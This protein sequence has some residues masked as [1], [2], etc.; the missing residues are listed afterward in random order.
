[1]LPDLVSF[2]PLFIYAFI[3]RSEFWDLIS[4][5]IWVVAYAKE[6]YK[7]TH[8]VIIFLAV[9][10]AVYLLR[11]KRWPL[12]MFGWGLHIVLD[13]FTHKDFYQTPFL[14][15][16]SNYKFDHGV[17]WG[18]PWFMAVNYGTMILV[19]ALIYVFNRQNRPM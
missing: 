15:P 19:Y 10:L 16:I 7:Y 5:N 2:S 17:S 4:K 18:E 1:M 8:S 3:T 11:K 6:S 13:I 12:P 14:F 9:V